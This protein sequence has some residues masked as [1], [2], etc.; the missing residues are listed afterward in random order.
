MKYTFRDEATY[1]A[2]MRRLCILEGHFPKPPPAHGQ[3]KGMTAS[4]AASSANNRAQ[5]ISLFIKGHSTAVIADRL[6]LNVK[7]IRQLVRDTRREMAQ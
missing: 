6:N 2:D 3:N 7:T 5:A 4:R 1:A